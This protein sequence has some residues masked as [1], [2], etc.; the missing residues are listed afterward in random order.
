MSECR[1]LATIIGRRVALLRGKFQ[2]RHFRLPVLSALV[3]HEQSPLHDARAHPQ[4]R[5]T[6]VL[7][8]LPGAEMGL[9]A[10]DALPPPRHLHHRA[11]AV[12]EVPVP[13][14]DFGLT[15]QIGLCS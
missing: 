14:Q 6:H 3:H 2:A 5:A 1:L 13:P 15:F 10:D 8:P 12:L 7:Y 11:V 4:R 9:E